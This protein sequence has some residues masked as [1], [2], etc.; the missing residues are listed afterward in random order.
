[1]VNLLLISKFVR[2]VG[3]NYYIVKTWNMS[4]GTTNWFGELTMSPMVEGILE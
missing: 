2:R 4:I 1:M 3:M